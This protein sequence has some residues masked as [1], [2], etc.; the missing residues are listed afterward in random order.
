MV[1]LSMMG[2]A[3]TMGIKLENMDTAAKPGTDF[4][5]YACGGWMKNNPLRPEF[6]RYGSFDVVAEENQKRIREIIEGLA[7]KPQTKGSLGQKIGDLYALRMDSVRQNKDGVAPVMVDLKRVEAVK[8]TAELIALVNQMNVEGVG[9]GELWGSYVGADMMESTQNIL[10]ISQ[11]GYSLERDYYVKDDEANKKI[12]EAYRKHIVKMFQFVGETPAAAQKKME[13]IVALETRMAKAGRDHVALRDPASNYHKMSFV[14]FT[15]EYAGFDWKT[16]FDVQGLTDIDSLSVGQPEAVKEALAVLADTPVEVLKDWL[17]WQILDSAGSM[18]GDTVYEEVFDFNGRILT[19][20]KEPR[21][22]WK[23]SVSIV[24]SV[25]GEAVGQLYAYPHPERP[26]DH[27][28]RHH[29]HVAPPREGVLVVAVVALA[30]VRLDVPVRPHD[31]RELL[32][33]PRVRVERRDVPGDLLRRLAEG[34]ADVAPGLV[35][36]PRLPRLPDRAV[37]SDDCPRAGEPRVNRV[38]DAVRPSH[39]DLPASPVQ[40]FFLKVPTRG[41]MR[42]SS[43]HCFRSP[44][45]LDFTWST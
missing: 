14:D 34:L 44:F 8:T 43:P 40:L 22:R 45:W 27:H 3:Q 31:P 5:Q 25:L 24:N 12:L 30:V 36:L 33:A 6:A 20:A 18:L 26:R 29:V 1:A 2:N 21:P 37:R 15:K 7:E 38:D 35:L 10:E 19:G 39:A 23:R 28:R 13:N 41:R 42:L 16:Y 17:Q 11:G 9:F 32:S 4:Y